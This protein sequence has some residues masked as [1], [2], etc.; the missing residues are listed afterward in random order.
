MP[1]SIIIPIHNEE[2]SIPKLLLRLQTYANDH[3]ILIIDDG[4]TDG[5][6]ASLSDCQFI[7]LIHFEKNLGKGIAIRTGIENAFNDKIIISDGDLELD[8]LEIRKLMILDKSSGIKC[9]FGSRYE[10][11]EPFASLWGFG[12]FF[13][14]GLFNMVYGSD[15]SDVLCCAKAF[16]KSD[17]NLEKISAVGFD[18]D[19]ELAANLTKNSF[20]IHTVYLSYYRRSTEE[21]KKL[22]FVDGWSIFKRILN[23]C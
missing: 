10:N 14:T 1:Y 3:E 17:L 22:H 18:I 2:N 4:S 9:A 5:S 12:N 19:V 15:H 7:T 23:T 20:E 13:F 21:G 8:P 11:I 16:F 6:Y